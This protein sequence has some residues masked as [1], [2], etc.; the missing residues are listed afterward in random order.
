MPR[1]EPAK[2]IHTSPDKAGKSNIEGLDMPKDEDNL[3]GKILPVYKKG[4]ENDKTYKGLWTEEQ[5]TTCI[6]EF[7]QYCFEVGLKP[8]KPALQ[9]WLSVSRETYNQWERFPEKYGYK[10]DKI[11]HANRVMEFYLQANLDKY[12]T[13]SI[14]LLKTSHGHI[15][16][17]KIDVTSNGHSMTQSAD[18][19]KDLISK[20]GLDKK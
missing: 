10:S 13:G 1:K 12:P 19:V 2:G 6:D 14:F 7:F 18:D 5:F 17:S 3:M 15:E 9:L 4:Q 20:L 16:Q 8:T 11:N